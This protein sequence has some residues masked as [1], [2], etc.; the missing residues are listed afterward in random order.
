MAGE[1]IVG[2]DGE[3]GS[4]T[5]LQTAVAIAAAFKRPLVITFGYAPAPIGGEVAD[6]SRAV[7]DIGEKITGEAV[8]QAHAIDASVDTRVELVNDRPADA[9]LRAADQY[10]AL[11]IVVGS[12]GRGPIAGTVLG[13]V[14]YQ[15]VHRANRP[16]V[17]V[18]SP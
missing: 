15:V 5:A 7:Q 1:V 2:Y 4:R 11:A 10:D 16:V 18:P 14:T 12:T 8:D 17:V 3:P 13:S 9:L 6:L